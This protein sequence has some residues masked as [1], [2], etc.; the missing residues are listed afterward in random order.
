[1]WHYFNN[2]PETDLPDGM[3]D[4]IRS[5]Y[6]KYGAC[7]EVCLFAIRKWLVENRKEPTDE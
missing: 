5:A 7:G 3:F 1:M 6:K 4:E 2:V